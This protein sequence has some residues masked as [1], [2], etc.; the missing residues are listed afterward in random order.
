MYISITEMELLPIVM[1]LLVAYADE[2]IH[3]KL[4]QDLKMC[5]I[6]ELFSSV[7]LNLP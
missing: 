5:I 4:M 2:Q 3:V 7:I 6:Y 1:L